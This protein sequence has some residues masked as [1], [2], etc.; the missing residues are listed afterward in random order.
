MRSGEAS[1]EYQ[2][3]RNDPGPLP[4]LERALRIAK[5]EPGMYELVETFSQATGDA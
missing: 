2:V 3:M 1:R 5:F 4:F